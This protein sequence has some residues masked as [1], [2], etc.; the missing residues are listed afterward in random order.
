MTVFKKGKVPENLIYLQ[1]TQMIGAFLGGSSHLIFIVLFIIYDVDLMLW[2][3]VFVSLPVFIS[4]FIL[5]YRGKLRIPPVI[6]TIEVAVHQM[7]GVFLIGQETGFQVLLFCLIPIGMLFQKWKVSFFIN[8]SIAL[9]LYLTIVWFDKGQFNIFDLTTNALTIIRV[10]NSLALFAIVGIILFYYISLNKKLYDRIQETNE[11]LYH[12]NNELNV[13]IGLLN[14]QKDRIESQ[15]KNITDSIN[16]ARR[17]Q[18]ALLP[19]KEI[20][21]KTIPD[22]FILFLPKEVVSGDF[23][24]VTQ[25]DE[26]VVFCVADC[27]GHGV[28]GAFMSLLGIAFLDEIVNR[29][30]LISTSEILNNLRI[31]VIKALKQTGRREDQIDGMDIAI[32]CYDKN[33]VTIEFS[34]ANSP[35]Y[36]ISN[37]ELEE[38][39][40]DKM[41]IS[42][43]PGKQKSFQSKTLNISQGDMVYIF[44][45]GYAD[46]FGGSNRSKYKISQLKVYIKEIHRS[47]VNKQKIL[48]EKNFNI[49]KGKEEQTDDVI[50]MGIRF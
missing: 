9:I 7:L 11:K 40:P 10:I 49:W 25:V 33:S 42:Y 44:S 37:G 24:W 2:F 31:E 12:I 1:E 36:L 4:A 21:E 32:C 35:L 27:T 48:L 13:T 6:G 15:N 23:F 8:S 22:H 5:S 28:P 3:N 38:L 34:G 43:F 29:R 30:K 20:L 18:T 41:P 39:A 14:R 16:Y 26:K 47:P 19:Q 45:D 46:Q 50:L 17:I